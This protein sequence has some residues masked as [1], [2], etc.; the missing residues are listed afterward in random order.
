MTKLHASSSR[1]IAFMGS[2]VILF[3]FFGFGTVALYGFATTGT[4]PATLKDI[5]DYLLAGLTLF[6]PYTVNKFAKLFESFN[7]KK[8]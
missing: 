6:A 3:I 7:P 1:L 8:S 2:L 4:V 5:T